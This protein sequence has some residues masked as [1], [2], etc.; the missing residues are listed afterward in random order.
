MVTQ[1]KQWSIYF[2]NNLT[3]FHNLVPRLHNTL[4]NDMDFMSGKGML[5]TITLIRVR[6]H[7]TNTCV[8]SN[9]EDG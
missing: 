7:C 2:W 5:M 3:M 9:L 6:P 4:N 8:P 1:Q